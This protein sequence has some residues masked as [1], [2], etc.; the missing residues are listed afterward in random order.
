MLVK[1]IFVNL[2]FL[3]ISI[4]SLK[5]QSV[6]PLALNMG[7]GYAGMMEWS[8]GESASIG[9]FYGGSYFLNTGLLQPQTSV[10]TAI[11]EF[12][13][14]VFGH[15]VI[16]GPIPT[17]TN[18]VHLKT[19]FDRPGNLKW[20]LMDARSQILNNTEVGNINSTY[21]HDIHLGD[22]PSGVFYIK[23]YYQ[24]NAG[25]LQTGIYKIIKL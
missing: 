13:P 5:A 22:F 14:A 1:R 11:N 21:Y 15:Q 8:I 4:I 3:F 25:A 6:T 24:S 17:T 10:V 18:L 2:I 23:I 7:G 12:G 20:Q 9:H 16:I 19:Q